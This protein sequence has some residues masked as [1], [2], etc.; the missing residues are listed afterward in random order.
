MAGLGKRGITLRSAQLNVMLTNEFA[1][2]CSKVPGPGGVETA[3]F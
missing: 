1:S 3:E 2:R